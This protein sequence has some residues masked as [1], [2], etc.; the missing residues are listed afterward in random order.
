MA[1]KLGDIVSQA[2][3]DDYRLM[4]GKD[5]DITGVDGAHGT[6]ADADMFLVDVNAA[7]TQAS[8]KSVLGSVLK[9]YTSNAPTLVTPAL[10]TPA[11]G[12]LSNCTNFPVPTTITVADESTDTTCFP[13]FATADTGNLG[14]KTGSNLTFNSATGILTATG[15]S[16]PITGDVTGNADTATK[17]A[18]I[19]NSD[20]VQLTASQTLTNKTL[21]APVIADM[22]NCTFPTLNQSTT[23]NATTATTAATATEVTATANNSANETVYLTFVDGTTSSQGIETATALTYNPGSEILTATSF[24]GAWVGSAI[25]LARG[26]TGQ[27][28]AAAAANALLNTDQGGSLTIGAA[29][30]T[31][32]VP[33]TLSVTGSINYINST[34]TEITDKNILLAASAGS[35]T[36]ADDAAA[37]TAASGGGISLET[38]SATTANYA[39][40]VWTS[41]DPLTG[42]SV[43]DTGA[44]AGTIAKF[45]LAIQSQSTSALTNEVNAP[46]GAFHYDTSGKD[47]YI[48]ID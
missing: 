42:W 4:N 36:Y 17:I 33:G 20:I 40:L 41:A 34:N 5:L 22:S 18:T 26:G 3:S 30:D 25:P 31:I 19:T 48:R 47:L 6:L 43:K 46:V 29:S 14:P 45:P 28:T 16:G 8:T 7:G 44:V 11:S 23:G 10:G 1:V 39:S 21:T 37:V 38:D 9:T 32:T 35:S 15:F 12:N 27:A 2:G 24:S 13:L